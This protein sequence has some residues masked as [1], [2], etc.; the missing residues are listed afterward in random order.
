MFSLN[1]HLVHNYQLYY[2]ILLNNSQVNQIPYQSGM[3]SRGGIA[4]LLVN[5][6]IFSLRKPYC[7]TTKYKLPAACLLHS[8][9]SFLIKNRTQYQ[10]ENKAKHYKTHVVFSS[11]HFNHKA[12]HAYSFFA[13][14]A[15][16][17]NKTTNKKQNNNNKKEKEEGG[18]YK[19]LQPHICSV[20]ARAKMLLFCYQFPACGRRCCGRTLTSPQFCLPALHAYMNRQYAEALHPSIV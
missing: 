8:F 20:I 11:F 3:Y 14:R 17:K 5:P 6:C 18:K 19:D 10:P 7:F 16:R 9:S 15:G 1:D 13:V 4:Q 12:I 2:H